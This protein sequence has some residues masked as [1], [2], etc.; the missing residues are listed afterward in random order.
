MAVSGIH[1]HPLDITVVGCSR[2]RDTEWFSRQDPYV[3]LEYA[4][5]RFRTKT[6]TDGG[7]NP[8]FNEKFVLPLIEGLREINVSVWNS[9][10][11]SHDDLIG[12]GKI[13]LE[14]VLSNGYDDSTWPLLSRSGK[15]A[16]E[17]RLILHYSNSNGGKS[18]LKIDSSSSAFPGTGHRPSSGYPPY[19]PYSSYP[20]T[21]HNYP[22]AAPYPSPP[23]A[24]PP[25]SGPYPPPAGA[26]PPYETAPPP[27]YPPSV[28]PPQAYPPSTYPPT[29]YSPAGYP[30]YP[31]GYPGY[32][33]G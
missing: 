31:P 14:K 1:N 18:K 30:S 17:V 23:N 19:Q 10:T 11:L 8:T 24:Y 6:C 26:Y 9:N 25:P 29:A 15:N 21:S 20:S 33:R 3:C 4:S 22:P 12:T 16:G 7:K 5:S 27:A 32:S 2:L 13:Y 28:Y